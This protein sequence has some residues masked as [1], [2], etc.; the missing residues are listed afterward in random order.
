MT[1]T[2]WVIKGYDDANNCDILG[3]MTKQPSRRDLALLPKTYAMIEV[4]D[5]ELDRLLTVPARQM[6]IKFSPSH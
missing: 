1:K 3:V 2:I 4:E 6:K 5:H